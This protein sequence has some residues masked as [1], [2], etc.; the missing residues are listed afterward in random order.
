M[1]SKAYSAL[2]ECLVKSAEKHKLIYDAKHFDTHFGPENIVMVYYEE[3]HREGKSTKLISRWIGPYR[4]VEEVSPVTYKVRHLYTGAETT[5][6]VQ[7]LRKIV[8]HPRIL[9]DAS[10]VALVPVVRDDV[11]LAKPP[12]EMP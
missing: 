12:S 3:A 7:R 1:L 8:A 4:I 5:A 2:H 10:A 6:H 11:D 9:N